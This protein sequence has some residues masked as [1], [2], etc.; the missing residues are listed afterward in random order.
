VI[1]QNKGVGMTSREIK[2]YDLDYEKTFSYFTNHIIY[3][4]ALSKHVLKTANLNTGKFFTFLPSNAALKRLYDFNHGIIPSTP[5]GMQRYEIKNTGETFHPTQVVNMDRECSL[6]ISAFL[7][8][9]PKHYCFVENYMLTSD[10]PFA[11]IQNVKLTPYENEVYY[12][13]S[14]HN[15]VGEIELTVKKS[16]EVWHFLSVLTILQ[17]GCSSI[18]TEEIMY[19][20]S[21]KARYI[22][23]GAYDEEG[24]IVW[25]TE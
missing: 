17:E 11:S 7:N 20:I 19:R 22:V 13:L 2:R 14:C 8:Q 25:S 12:S 21:E 4:K 24:Y 15:S 16:G 9:N 1:I 5:Y 10:S 3:G 18:L 23:A 6:F